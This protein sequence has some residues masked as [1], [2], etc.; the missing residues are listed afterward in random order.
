MC[1]HIEIHVMHKNILQ[2]FYINYIHRGHSF[3]LYLK[4]FF[5]RKSVRFQYTFRPFEGGIY[6][7]IIRNK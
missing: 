7:A 6:I 4:H 5:F 3:Y 2:V 1:K